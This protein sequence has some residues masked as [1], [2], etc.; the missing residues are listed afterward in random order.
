[1]LVTT[2]AVYPLGSLDEHTEFDEQIAQ[3]LSPNKGIVGVGFTT[4]KITSKTRRRPRPWLLVTQTD[5]D[6]I[7]RT[8]R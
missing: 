7:N 3:V 5:S 8:D 1:M 2:L 6:Q 4:L